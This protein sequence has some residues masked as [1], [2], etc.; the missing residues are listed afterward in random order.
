MHALGTCAPNSRNFKVSHCRHLMSTHLSPRSLSL[1][2]PSLSHA[3]RPSLLR[4]LPCSAPSPPPCT[5]EHPR[6]LL[7]FAAA[8]GPAAEG[9]GRGAAYPR[10]RSGGP[11]SGGGRHRRGA[12][13]ASPAPALL[14]VAHP[15]AR[16]RRRSRGP[17]LPASR[18]I[19]AAE[20]IKDTAQH[21]KD[22]RRTRR[23]TRRA[24]ATT[25]RR[26][27]S[28]RRPTPAATWAR[29]PTRPSTRPARPPRPPSTDRKSVV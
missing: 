4:P 9:Q 14:A 12:G 7:E 19:S 8:H 20:H 3:H 2:P 13:R 18:R 28:R 27:P 6:R 16:S 15:P 22:R 17:L 29:R 25:P 24:R 11:R 21:A 1:L 5:G 26:R 23:G 10:R